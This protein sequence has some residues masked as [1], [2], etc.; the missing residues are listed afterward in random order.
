M[1]SLVLL[2]NILIAKIKNNKVLKV[3]V[4]KYLLQMVK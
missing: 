4:N 2:D 1:K 3:L